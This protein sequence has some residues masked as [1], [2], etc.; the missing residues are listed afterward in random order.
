MWVIRITSADCQ[1]I[2]R[3]PDQHWQQNLH[4]ILLRHT[5]HHKLLLLSETCWRL[6]LGVQPPTL[7]LLNL[8]HAAWVE[9]EMD[10]QYANIIFSFESTVNKPYC[11]NERQLQHISHWFSKGKKKKSNFP[12][13]PMMR[14][15][16]DQEEQMSQCQMLLMKPSFVEPIDICSA[17]HLQLVMPTISM[18]TKP[19]PFLGQL[20]TS[21]R[22]SGTRIIMTSAI[23]LGLRENSSATVYLQWSRADGIIS[24][25][26][27]NK[28]NRC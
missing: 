12:F 27:N 11:V 5:C 10:Q 7:L 9:T 18:N 22:N 15:N 24:E 28:C 23:M 16:E 21:F 6:L 4:H 2:W 26:Q 25:L 8:Q 1:L 20:C 17:C 13:S 3:T 19:R 14:Q